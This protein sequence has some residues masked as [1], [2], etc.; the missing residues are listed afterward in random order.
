MFSYTNRNKKQFLTGAALIPGAA[1]AFFLGG[2]VVSN[3]F[4]VSVDNL[5]CLEVAFAMAVVFGV[6]TLIAAAVFIYKALRIR[7]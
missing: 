7:N 4:C 3:L 5:E 2:T 1:A 6:I